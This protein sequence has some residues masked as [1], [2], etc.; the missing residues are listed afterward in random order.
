VAGAQRNSR[1]PFDGG[2]DVGRG[3]R[4]CSALYDAENGAYS[5][6][7]EGGDASALHFVHVKLKGDFVLTAR[8][9]FTGGGDAAEVGWIA[10]ASLAPD[11]PSVAA[12]VRRDGSV[13]LRSHAPA[14]DET[15]ASV[16][17]ADVVELRR[18]G[19]TF[20]LAAAKFG[21]LFETVAVTNAA[22]GDEVE[23]GLFG[24]PHGGAVLASFRNVRVVVPAPA[25]LVPYRDYLGSKL[26]LLELATGE[27]RVIYEVTD[28]LQAPNWTPDDRALIYNRNGRL[29]RF[30]LRSGTPEEINTAFATNL[31]NDH[32][33]SFDGKMLGISHG[34]ADDENR[35]VVYTVPVEGGTPKRITAKSPSYLHGWSPD[36]K[37]LV[38]TGQ[39]DGDFDIYKIPAEGGDEV[40]LTEAKGLDDGPEYSPDGRYI[41]FNSARTGR[42][43]IW[44]MKPDGSEQTQLTNDELNNWFP[45]LS[46][47]G[48]E[49]VF[50]SFPKEVDPSDHPFYKHVY[51]RVM[52]VDGGPPRVVAYL[53][54]GQGTINVPSWAP[55]GKRLAF[56]SNTKTAE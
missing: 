2:R 18:E 40:R 41:Y 34:S 26:E 48:K 3:L 55:D 49:M 20:V 32:V 47:D 28:S 22:L 37:W 11:A 13:S 33:L 38:Y 29:Y 31:N 7:C 14:G 12:V 36:G 16:K 52:P 35:S 5:I 6:S 53:Y 19:S 51:L 10:R 25:D 24:A 43:E 54:G 56:V 1:R 46:P 8:V 27:R 4:G 23:V 44:R 9:R 50:V 39:R 30:D 21:D 17:G 45:H 42:M 15:K